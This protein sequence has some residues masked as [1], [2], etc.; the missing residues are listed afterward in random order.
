MIG[1]IR[2]A[3]VR[4]FGGVDVDEPESIEDRHR[5]ERLELQLEAILQHPDD[6]SLE[7]RELALHVV[8]AWTDDAASD[9]EFQEKLEQLADYL[10]RTA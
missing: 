4:A 10:V 6:R 3:L 9:E 5:R 1:R 8:C 2:R 7:L